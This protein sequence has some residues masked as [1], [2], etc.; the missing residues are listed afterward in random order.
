MKNWEHQKPEERYSVRVERGGKPVADI[1]S[2]DISEVSE[3]VM[4]WRKANHIH[5]WFVDNVQKQDDNCE[6]FYVSN[7]DLNELLKVC[8][9][10]IKNSKLVDGEVYAGTFYNRENPKGQVQ[11]IAG[12][13]IEDATVAKELLPTQEGFFFGSHEY[14]E[15]YLDEVVRTRD[16]LVKMLDDI[17]NGSEGDIY[18]S[19]SW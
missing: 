9:K 15:Y 1:R 17:K 4:Y 18:Y 12:K 19:S 11:R 2:E 7:D 10:V 6:S 3:E 16:W 14:D 8:N 5:K 13:V